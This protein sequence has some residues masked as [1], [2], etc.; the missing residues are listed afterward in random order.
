MRTG[1][2]VMA[3]LA[4]AVV[5]FSAYALTAANT[6]PATGAGQ[7][8]GTITTYTVSGADHTLST[9]N[10]QLITATAFTID[11]PYPSEARV[12]EAK[13]GS[14]AYQSC[15]L[16]SSTATTSTWSCP[17]PNIS[18]TGAGSLQVAAAQ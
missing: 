5:A 6:V 10:P 2:V 1:R 11:A 8:A 9:S 13:L 15:S 3:L 16:S 4:V 7:G 14:A 17:V 12:V 18:V